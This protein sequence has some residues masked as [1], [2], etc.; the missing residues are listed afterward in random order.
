MVI[1]LVGHAL[2]EVRG[3]DMRAR[4]RQIARQELLSAPM[5]ID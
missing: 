2:H 5:R 3:D 4:R 1:S